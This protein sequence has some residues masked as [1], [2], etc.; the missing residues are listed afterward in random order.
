MGDR[1]DARLA[2]PQRR[3][4]STERCLPWTSGRPASRQ[5]A[6]SAATLFRPRIVPFAP[7]RLVEPLLDI[8]RGAAQP[9]PAAPVAAQRFSSSRRGYGRL[10]EKMSSA[11]GVGPSPRR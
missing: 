7:C 2:G 10:E 6:S 5:A 1:W 4:G 8:L 9:S 3:L 11:L